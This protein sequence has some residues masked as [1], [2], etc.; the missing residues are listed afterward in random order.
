MQKK[1]IFIFGLLVFNSFLLSGDFGKKKNVSSPEIPEQIK[2]LESF[3]ATIVDKNDKTSKVKDLCFDGSGLFF[4]A[5]DQQNDFLVSLHDLKSLEVLDLNQ[6]DPKFVRI[7]IVFN[8]DPNPLRALHLEAPRELRVNGHPFFAEKSVFQ[9]LLGTIKKIV[10]ISLVKK[11]EISKKDPEEQSLS[12][13]EEQIKQE[14]KVSKK[15]EEVI[16][17]KNVDVVSEE[18]SKGLLSSWLK[19]TK[20]AWASFKKKLSGSA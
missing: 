19:N 8:S 14:E 13:K 7:K 16:E 5:K 6:Q 10:D 17:A 3:V 15:P 12:I 11:K 18:P 1:L 4:T 9:R 20:N 2:P